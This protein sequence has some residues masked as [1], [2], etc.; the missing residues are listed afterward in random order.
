MQQGG[1]GQKESSMVYFKNGSALLG[2]EIP[3]GL[4]AW[5]YGP[6]YTSASETTRSSWV[7]N[8]L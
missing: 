3:V 6:P 2:I 8:V 1:L 4:E 7:E 5:L